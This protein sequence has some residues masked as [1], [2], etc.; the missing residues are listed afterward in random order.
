MPSE[1]ICALRGGRKR[2]SASFRCRP[3]AR[4]GVPSRSGH[5]G[6]GRALPALEYFCLQRTR[7]SSI[8]VARMP[9]A[10]GVPR[11]MLSQLVEDNAIVEFGADPKRGIC[12][13]REQQTVNVVDTSA[14][15][16]ARVALQ[17]SHRAC[18]PRPSLPGPHPRPRPVRCML[19]GVLR[20]VE[21][22]EMAEF[23]VRLFSQEGLDASTRLPSHQW[24]EVASEVTGAFVTGG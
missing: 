8:E 5:F 21:G 7:C 14:A 18:R 3:L 11:T 12:K 10:P 24:A 1:N 19:A 4:R 17:R 6:R 9:N 15:N 20:W 13:P 22:S 23:D 2:S 16:S